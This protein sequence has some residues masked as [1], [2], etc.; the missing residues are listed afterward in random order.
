MYNSVEEYLQK[1]RQAAVERDKKER[2]QIMY[3]EGLMEKIYATE[4]SPNTA[5]YPYTDASG[6]RYKL[7]YLPITDEQYEQVKQYVVGKQKSKEP[8]TSKPR[9]G[10]YGNIGGK[11]KTLAVIFCVLGVLF[12]VISG[13]FTIV[14]D[15]ST[16][17]VV[18]GILVILVGAVLSWIG[19]F[20]LYGFG[21]MVENS[22]K[23]V[24]L[25]Q[26]EIDKK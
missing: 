7:R 22:D 5:E 15:A 16:I 11:I 6:K 4:A 8:I 13:I 12:S 26:Q 25:K 1:Q 20:V 24:A 2:Q 19:S 21:Q 23:L 14:V 17:S 10:L 18:K 3:Q 9:G